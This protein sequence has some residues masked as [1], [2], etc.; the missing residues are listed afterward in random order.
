MKAHRNVWL[1]ALAFAVVA[2]ALFL[3]HLARPHKLV[4]D[5]VHYVPAARALLALSGPVNIEHPLLGKELIALGIRLFGDNSFGWRFFS[6]IAATACVLGVHWIA[7]MLWRSRRTALIAG[8]V[9]LL[10]IT[11]FIQ[12]RIAML[13]GF[14]AALVVN[15]L[16]CLF[17]AARAP[18]PGAAWRRWLAGAVLLGLATATKWLAAPY[19]AL[20]GVAL[21]VARTRGPTFLPAVPAVLALG[22]VSIAAYFTTFAPAFFYAADPLTFADLLPFQRAMYAQQTQVLPHHPYQSAWWSWPLMIRPIWYLYERADGAQR[23]ILLLGNPAVLWGGLVAVAA[24]AWAGMRG[25][26]RM[27]ATAGLWAF[28]LAIWALIPKSLGFF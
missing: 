20:A 22:A 11:V 25:D 12:A 13:D 21:L 14:M 10:N 23:G 28:S 15:G 3:L 8:A 19:I 17:W 7:W 6:T 24:S 27:L 4:F 9:T 2:Q 26:G 1:A 5:E 18:T 16:A